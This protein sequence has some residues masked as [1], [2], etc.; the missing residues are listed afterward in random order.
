MIATGRERLPVSYQQQNREFNDK[1]V[2]MTAAA[3]VALVMLGYASPL[4]LAI[5]PALSWAIGKFDDGLNSNP[6]NRL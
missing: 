5:V 6:R 4:A 1:L 2:A 3:M